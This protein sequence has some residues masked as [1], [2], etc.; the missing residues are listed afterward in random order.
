[1]TARRPRKPRPFLLPLPTIILMLALLV[2]IIYLWRH[3]SPD[4]SKAIAATTES[5]PDPSLTPGPMT[6]LGDLSDVATSSSLPEIKK[7]YSAFNLSFNPMLHIPNWV[8]WTLTAEHAQATNPR[9]DNFR[10]DYDVDG[11]ATLQDYRKSGYSR[12]HMAPSADMKFS[13]QAMDEACY[14]TNIAPQTAAYNSGVWS[15]IERKCRQ[16]AIADSVIYIVTG[17]IIDGNPIDYIGPSQV[18]VP[19]AFFKAVISPYANPPRGIGFIVPQL[20]HTG[21]MQS[22]T[23][24]I[25]SIEALT[26]HDFFSSLPDQLE[27]NIEAQNN[28]AQWTY[29][30]PK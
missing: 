26:G 15:S 21:G 13:P 11:C 29:P 14:L 28:F 20:G 19:R 4:S 24:S 10:P 8:A 17:P 1:M 12:G 25:D 3:L 18:Y 5:L 30:A 22:A 27:N 7:R 6:D 16:W 2:G 23:V 9:K